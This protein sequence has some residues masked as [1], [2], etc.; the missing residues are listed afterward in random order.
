MCKS[1]RAIKIQCIDSC[2]IAGQASDTQPEGGCKHEKHKTSPLGVVEWSGWVN[3]LMGVSP[4]IWGKFKRLGTACVLP[5][6]LF[7]MVRR[8][9]H[10]QSGTI[11]NKQHE[12]H[13]K[14]R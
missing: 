7:F 3:G 1:N 10:A 11:D 5:H 9:R 13:L 4:L 8:L 12:G 6:E 2:W 14:V